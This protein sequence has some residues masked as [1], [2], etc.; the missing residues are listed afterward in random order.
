MSPPPPPP[1]PPP[2]SMPSAHPQQQ[3]PPQQQ[4]HPPPPTLMQRIWGP[5]WPF[6]SGYFAYRLVKGLA[7]SLRELATGSPRLHPDE[8]TNASRRTSLDKTIRGNSEWMRASGV[9]ADDVRI[10]RS[11]Q[12]TLPRAVLVANT[13][14]GALLRGG[15]ASW[16]YW[17]GS[18]ARAARREF[19][20]WPREGGVM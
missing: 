8:R 1:P 13:V 6:V 11:V 19:E 16:S 17:H 2:P 18:R 14:A 20:E 7:W 5:V 10:M 9:D 4:I 15:L 12:R 3:V